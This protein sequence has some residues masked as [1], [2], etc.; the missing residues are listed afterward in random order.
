VNRC[1][2]GYV[3]PFCRHH[4][5]LYDVLNELGEGK[6]FDLQFYIGRIEL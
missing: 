6:G 5:L 4:K 3:L 1:S 2:D